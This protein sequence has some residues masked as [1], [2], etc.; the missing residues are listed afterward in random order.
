MKKQILTSPPVIHS[1]DASVSVPFLDLSRQFKSIE[2]EILTAVSAVCVSQQYI[3]GPEVSAFEKETAAFLGVAEAIGCANGTDALWL[4]LAACGI[5][6]GDS[7]I[8]T[9]FTFIATASAIQRVGARPVF[10]D[11]DPE[12]LN[13]SP[14]ATEVMINRSRSAR[15]RALL[16]VHLYGLCA[17]MDDLDRI[18]ERFKLVMIEDAAQAFGATWRGKRA[19]SLSPIAAFSFYPTKNLNCAGDGGMV[20]TQDLALAAKVKLLRNYGSPKRY[21]HEETGWNSRLDS[22]QAAILRVKLKH[23]DKWNKKRAERAAAYDLLLR[24]AGLLAKPGVT[25]S[26]APVRILAH[27]RHAGHVYHQY[28][29]RCQRRDELRAFLAERK[30]GSEVYYPLPIHLQKV[31][32]YLGYAPGSFPEAEAASADV[33][34]LPI[35]PEITAEEQAT[36]VNAISEFYT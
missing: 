1:K 14:A 20:T 5:G 32:S 28:V 8:T 16:P 10:A 3:L 13:I 36:V 33:L 6:S 27:D 34:A 30:I 12:T 17:N 23:I 22:I 2:K 35:F 21:Y 31:Y 18:A 9:P 19:G 24:S 4:A 15:F 29:I 25:E 11:I 26:L 7:V